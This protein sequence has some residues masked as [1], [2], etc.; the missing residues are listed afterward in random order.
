MSPKIG[1]VKHALAQRRDAGGHHCSQVWAA[2]KRAVAE[3]GD[4]HGERHMLEFVATGKGPVPDLSGAQPAGGS[5]R[6]RP[7]NI[8][9]G[10]QVVWD[11][12]K[13]TGHWIV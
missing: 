9:T 2:G 5:D 12:A 7:R 4:G 6:L 8:C 10:S 3:L 13:G 11:F 1:L